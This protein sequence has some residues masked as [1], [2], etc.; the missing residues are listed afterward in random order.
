[1][2]ASCYCV[3]VNKKDKMK[4]PKS[5]L[6]F[7][8]LSGNLKNLKRSGWMKSGISPQATESVA[9]HSWRVSLIALCLGDERALR[10]AVLH[11]LQ[12]IL[13][14]DIMPEKHSGI[15]RDQKLEM[16]RKAI[17]QLQNMLPEDS[18]VN[19]LDLWQE[20][21]E[22]KTETAILVKSI[23]KLEM[24][25]QANEYEKKHNISLQQFFDSTV[26]EIKSEKVKDIVDEL[27]QERNN[28][29]KS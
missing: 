7:I 28:K 12:E 17:L 22:G 25:I 2:A 20:M 1:M 23:D 6:S 5:L 21:E 16:E 18:S 10:M 26:D 4:S 15:T 9:D 27:V 11:D 8:S 29:S 3:L 14:G 19:L 13:A 24:L